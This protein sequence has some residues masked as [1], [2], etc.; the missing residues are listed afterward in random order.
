MFRNKVF[1]GFSAIFIAYVYSKYKQN[2]EKE[3]IDDDD[4]EEAVYESWKSTIALPKQSFSRII[5]G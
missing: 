5:V 1:L 3:E 4:W 2:V